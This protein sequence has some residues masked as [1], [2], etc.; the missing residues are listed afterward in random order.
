MGC[1]GNGAHEQKPR[2]RGSVE[3]PDPGYKE[4][5]RLRSCDRGEGAGARDVGACA[6][7][8][9]QAPGGGGGEVER[10]GVEERLR[11]SATV[12][13]V[14]G[15]PEDARGVGT[16]RDLA[17]SPAAIY[18]CGE[19]ASFPWRDS[20]LRVC[21]GEQYVVFSV[22]LLLHRSARLRLMEDS[23]DMDMSPL[24]PQNYLFGNCLAGRGWPGPGGLGVGWESS[25]GL[26]CGG[27]GV[28]GGRSTGRTLLGR[29]KREEGAAARRLESRRNP[30]RERPSLEPRALVDQ[31]AEGATLLAAR[32]GAAATPAPLPEKVHRV[33]FQA[34]VFFSVDY[35]GALSKRMGPAEQGL[36][37]PI[38]MIQ[39]SVGLSGYRGSHTFGAS[40]E[41]VG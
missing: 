41:F 7:R 40:E 28:G 5:A 3:G 21:S 10:R 9:R 8:A 31:S 11:K 37:C 39:M 12:R 1:A 27:R 25:Q 4:K 2:R 20:V 32:A 22:R 17:R 18:R 35:P 23:M 36:R 33:C 6:V 38:G 26:L 34:A 16:R 30:G 15:D 29:G 19:P 24:R 13:E 14:G